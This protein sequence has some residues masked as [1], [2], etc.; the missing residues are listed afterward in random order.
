MFVGRER[1]RARIDRLLQ[2]AR[3]G[4]SGA[5]LLHGEAGHR[6]DGADA[7]GPS[8]RRPG[9][10]C[11][12]PAIETE[13]DIPFAGLA[14]LVT[15]LL[16]RLDDI[17]EVQASALR[18]ALALGPADAARPLHG[19]GRPAQPARGGGRGAADPR[20]DRRR[21]VARRA[22]ARGVPVRW[23]PARRR[24]HRDARLGARRH[25]RG[26]ARGAVA[27]AAVGQAAR[28]RRGARAA[29]RVAGRP[30]GARGGRPARGD[31]G[32]QP[33]RP[34]GDPAPAVRRAARGPRAA[35]GA[36]AAGHRRRAGVP[37]RARRAAATTSGARCWSPPARTAG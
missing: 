28:R 33:A 32:R 20:R 37:A 14:E 25:D 10:A 23:P 13:S 8:A 30:A 24:G 2:E 21:A 29:D 17:P 19:P 27:G 6:Q 5:L 4:K 7:L 35:R 26:G 22:V 36:S 9:C 16:D 11:C 3:A 15:P 34:A 18:G 1:E 31:L 12:A